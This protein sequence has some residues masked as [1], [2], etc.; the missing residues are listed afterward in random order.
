M[1]VTGTGT[2]IGKTVITAAIAALALADGL[3]VAVLKPGQTGVGPA[4]RPAM[5]TRSADWSVR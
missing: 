4:T 5:S 2:E 3:R 1:L